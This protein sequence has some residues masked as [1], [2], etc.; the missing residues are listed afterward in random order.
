[1]E[2]TVST[3]P[4][5]LLTKSQTHKERKLWRD[6]KATITVN[7]RY[8]D[9]CGNGHNTF[10]I[11]GDISGGNGSGCIH[12][13]IAEAFP[14]YAHLIQWHLT[15]SDGPMHYVSNALYHAS[16]KD[17]WGYRKNEPKRFK[18]EIFFN[19]VPVPVREYEEK[20][21]KFLQETIKANP[22]KPFYNFTIVQ[23]DHEGR[24]DYKFSPRYT[25]EGFGDSWYKCP[26]KS[27]QEAEQFLEALQTCKIA[28]KSEC[29]EWGEGKTPDLEAARNAA[30]WPEA[31]LEDFTKEKLE[32]RLPKLLNRF[33][34]DMEALGFTY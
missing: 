34:A 11:T 31:S 6:S 14:E 5:S 20:F 26:F 32:A 15:S 1:M 24:S 3:L 33:K 28:F 29:V 10:A 19:D 21:I 27:L 4:A 9:Q 13:E 25:F 8:D 22:E 18:T 23:H 12:A 16:E 30:V 2:T 17:C 7:L